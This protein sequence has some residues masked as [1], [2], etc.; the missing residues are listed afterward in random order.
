MSK[1]KKDKLSPLGIEIE[2]TLKAT[3]ADMTKDA[4]LPKEQREYSLTDRMKVM[5]RALKLEA[6]RAKMEDDEGSFFNAAGGAED[7]GE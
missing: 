2:K 7:E 1:E 6:I 4:K 5:D 3:L